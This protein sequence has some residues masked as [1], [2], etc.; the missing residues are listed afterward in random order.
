MFDSL[1]N[2]TVA[3]LWAL[4]DESLFKSYLEL[5]KVLEPAPRFV[6]LDARPLGQLEFG[7]VANIK[8][9]K[10]N[11]SPAGI[12]EAFNFVFGMNEKTYQ[13]AP[14]VSY[15]Y[16]LNWI[17][18]EVDRIVEIENK[19]L[20]DQPDPLYEMAGAKALEMF[21]ELPVLDMLAQR[22]NQPPQIIETWSY[23]F[24]FSLLLM[25]KKTGEVRE[26]YDRLKKISKPK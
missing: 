23:N 26:N 1:E 19:M 14:V 24:V 15:F 7:Q 17:L 9:L 11:P 5:Q 2:I 20:A 18:K 12:L 4:E 3:E 13:A 8:E 6:G 22:Y 25:I 16:A 21:K 10:S